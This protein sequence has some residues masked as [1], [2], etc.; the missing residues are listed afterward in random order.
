M[1]Q[2]CRDMQEQYNHLSVNCTCV[3]SLYKIKKMY[4]IYYIV[5]SKEDIGPTC[6]QQYLCLS[7]LHDNLRHDLSFWGGNIESNGL[8]KSQ[9]RLM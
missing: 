1:T 3:G 6:H 2:Q 7:N 9:K 5:K 4:K 8:L